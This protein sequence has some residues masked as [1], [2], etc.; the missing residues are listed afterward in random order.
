[1]ALTIVCVHLLAEQCSRFSLLSLQAW[2]S[3]I[4]SMFK[5]G[6][7]NASSTTSGSKM[8]KVSVE[9]DSVCRKV[10]DPFHGGK[11][12]E[13]LVGAGTRNI[14]WSREKSVNI[15]SKG[16]SDTWTSKIDC[17]HLR[18]VVTGSWTELLKRTAQES[19]SSSFLST[20]D[21]SRSSELTGSKTLRSILDLKELCLERMHE[22]QYRSGHCQ[23]TDRTGSRGA[24][25]IW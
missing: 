16:R 19:R 13:L 9:I 24:L 25:I 17:S 1:M 23:S 22:D 18:L 4:Y 11:D 15:A 10:I 6:L 3:S 20:L 8:L 14:G 2:Q 12:S 21:L 7:R 5:V